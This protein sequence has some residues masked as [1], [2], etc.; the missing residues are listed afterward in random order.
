MRGVGKLLLVVALFCGLVLTLTGS[1]VLAA[2][3]GGITIAPAT[4]TLT[5]EEGETEKVG[6]FEITNGY[7]VPIGLTFV[8]EDSSAAKILSVSQ[9][10]VTLGPGQTVRQLA[11]LNDNLTLQPGS[12][13]ATLVVSV[14]AVSDANVTV[15]PSVRLPI[16][17]VKQSG[18][19][20]SIN[21]ANVSQQALRITPPGSIEATVVNDGNMIAIPRGTVTVTGPGG[22]VISQGV[23]NTASQAVTPGN[24]LVLTTTMTNVGSAVWPG[25]Y[26]T[27]V[28]Y[29]LGSG[30]TVRTA[31]KSYLY[32]AWWHILT[33]ILLAIA[34]YHLRRFLPKT[35]HKK[36]LSHA[37][38]GKH[39]FTKRSAA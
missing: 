36:S 18:A 8:F 29:G 19:V 14:A 25:V 23:L 21:I 34:I 15:S 13:Q 6:G 32:V 33:F 3:Q 39:L 10:S 16:V 38:P 17:I 4:L 7:D 24:S 30:Q 37:P 28:S 31:G 35:R 1:S 26:R 9:P 22:L 11:T 2:E 5:L 20:T 27:N 12:Q